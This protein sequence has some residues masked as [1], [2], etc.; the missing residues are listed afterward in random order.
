MIRW[1]W[2]AVKPNKQISIYQ[3]IVAQSTGAIVYAD[4]IFAV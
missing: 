2:Y 1:D 4:C 3:N